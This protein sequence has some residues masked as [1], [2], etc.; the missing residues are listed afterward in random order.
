MRILAAVAALVLSS[1]EV[2]VNC[3]VPSVR[4][5]EFIGHSIQSESAIA[6]VAVEKFPYSGCACVSW[7]GI[8]RRDACL[9]GLLLVLLIQACRGEQD[10]FV[11]DTPGR[12]VT[13]SLAANSRAGC[14][15]ATT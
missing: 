7:F 5:H 3:E 12:L 1:D 15:M 11:R 6:K 4:I 14:G 2:L 9:R 10:A 13:S 8:R